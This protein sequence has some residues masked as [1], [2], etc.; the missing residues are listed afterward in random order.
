LESAD[1]ES[2]ANA[3]AAEFLM[4]EAVIRPSLR[5]LKMARLLD[6]KREWGVSMQSLIE[7][8]HQ[9]GLLGAQQRTNLYKALSAKG[10]RT[11][12][13]GS[14][15]IAPEGPELTTEITKTLGSR[16]LSPA[17]IALIVGFA[18]PATNTLLPS[19]RLQPV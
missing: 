1:I 3:F 5:N 16:G 6:L 4:P 11:R 18:S 13:P 10:W 9:L 17:E 7:R 14:G 8:A 15:D 12:E 2:E 19:N